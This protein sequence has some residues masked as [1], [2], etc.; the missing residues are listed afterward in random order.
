MPSCSMPIVGDTAT[1]LPA[2][3]FSSS[4]RL[5]DP[6]RPRARRK[7]RS[8]QRYSPH[9]PPVNDRPDCGQRIEFVV[10]KVGRLELHAHAVAQRPQRHAQFGNGVARGDLT[11]RRH[12]FDQRRIR[13]IFAIGCNLTGLNLRKNAN[14]S[15][16]VGTLTPARSGAST[17]ITRLRPLFHALT[18]ALISSSSMVGILH[19]E[20]AFLYARYRFTFQYMP[21]VA[22]ET[23][24]R[25][26]IA[27]AIGLFHAAHHFLFRPILARAE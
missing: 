10:F 4:I 17:V 12:V 11:G 13:N 15:S 5:K 27:F 6:S 26:L 19:I 7:K 21:N 8:L 22:G 24:R 18:S 2:N 23:A 16:C 1:T 25:L 3:F 14:S 9:L 20:R